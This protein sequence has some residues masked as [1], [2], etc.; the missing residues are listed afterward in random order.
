[1]IEI[2]FGEGAC[3]SLKVAQGYGKGK[4][5]GGAVSVFIRNTDGT[6]PAAEEIQAAQKTAAG[7]VQYPQVEEKPEITID[8]FDKIQI[9]VGEVLKCEPVPKAKKLLVSQIRIGDEVRQI[10]SGIAKYYKPEEMVGKKVAV[11]TN[12]KPCK[13]CGVE[14]QGMILAAADDADN[15]SVLT[16]DKDMIAGSEIR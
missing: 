10:V 3:G 12:L 15:L 2:V 6:A 11:I 7:G 9:R 14:S 5:L 16:V 4:Y 13:L 8:D 1:M